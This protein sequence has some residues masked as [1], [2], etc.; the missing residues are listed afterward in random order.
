[1][2]LNFLLLF[3][4][5]LSFVMYFLLFPFGRPGQVLQLEHDSTGNG[6]CSGGIITCRLFLQTEIHEP[7]C[8][9][10]TERVMRLLVFDFATNVRT[11]MSASV[12]VGL[13]FATT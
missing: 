2:T 12:L 4:S 9:A 8:A 1:M 3:V 7:T 13:R 6:G 10:Q 11:S 5:F